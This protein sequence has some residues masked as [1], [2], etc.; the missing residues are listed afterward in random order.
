[1]TTVVVAGAIANKPH[2]GG[3][4]W[5]RLSFVLGLKRLGFDVRF[6]ERIAP[7]HCSGG[8]PISV[9]WTRLSRTRW[10]GSESA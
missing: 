9:T 3:A 5:T 1:M 6:V 2:N 8:G 10:L 7:E 4:T